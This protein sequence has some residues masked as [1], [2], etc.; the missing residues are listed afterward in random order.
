MPCS[1]AA[2]HETVAIQHRMNGTFGRNLNTGKS[3]N[4]ALANLTS[5]PGSV[6]ALHVQDIVFHLKRKVM[7]IVTGTPAPVSQ[8][9]NATFL[10]AIEDLVAGLARDRELSAEFRHRL[11][12]SPGRHQLQ[13]FCPQQ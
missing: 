9:L 11:P 7:G 4:Q 12:G 13:A 10:I 6:L 3:A 8:P 2:L 5:S 1:T